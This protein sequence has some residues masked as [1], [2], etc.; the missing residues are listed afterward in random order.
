MCMISMRIL[1]IFVSHKMD[2]IFIQSVES[3]KN[4]LI[5]PLKEKNHLDLCC[6]SSH[7]D[8]CYENILGKMLFNITCKERQFTKMIEVF[9][10]IEEHNIDDYDW[11]IKIRPDLYINEIID[12]NKLNTCNKDAINARVR[13]YLGPEINLHYATSYKVDSVWNHSWQYRDDFTTIVPDDQFVVF[14]N[15]IAKRAFSKI[16]NEEIKNKTIITDSKPFSPPRTH[17]FFSKVY[18]GM[19]ILNGL[20]SQIEFFHRDMFNV[21]NIPIQPIGVNVTFRNIQ[22]GDLIIKKS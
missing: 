16:T 18:T 7:G 9:K 2:D 3:I 19:N 13:F 20:K 21:R 11:Y 14:H 22:S 17:W 4:K 12:T 15:N 10:Y 8:N 1:I 6:I 5:K